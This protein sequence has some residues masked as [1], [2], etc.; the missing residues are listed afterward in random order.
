MTMASCA[1][2]LN[3]SER[4]EI[5]LIN[6]EIPSNVKYNRHYGRARSA[7]TKWLSGDSSPFLWISLVS[8]SVYSFT[9]RMLRNDT[10]QILATAHLRIFSC[11]FDKEPVKQPGKTPVYTG[12]PVT[13]TV[14]IHTSFH[15]AG[16]DK[17]NTRQY[18]M[19]YELE[20]NIKD[21]L[22]SGQKRGDFVAKA[23]M[24]RHRS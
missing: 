3:I 10:V 16:H 15:W 18:R 17:K 11:P 8:M 7:Q 9:R 24:S 5:I 20:E 22:L 12:Q 1:M 23:S 13:A 14:T 21:W 19:R 6:T 4:S 2:L